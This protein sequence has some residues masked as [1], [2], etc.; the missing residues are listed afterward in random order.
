MSNYDEDL[1]QRAADGDE[2]ATR[3]LSENRA[4]RG[5]CRSIPDSSLE[6]SAYAHLPPEFG[7][8]QAWLSD[9]ARMS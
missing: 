7:A 6:D 2:E 8:R 5:D 1:Q 3:R 9:R 4:F